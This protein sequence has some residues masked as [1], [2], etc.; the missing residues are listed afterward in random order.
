MIGLEYA[1]GMNNMR[2]N[3]ATVH[4]RFME[5]GLT[6]PLMKLLLAANC[7]FEA[8]LYTVLFQF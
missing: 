2:V 8:F 1:K 4:N 6:T 3:N 5:S 7:V